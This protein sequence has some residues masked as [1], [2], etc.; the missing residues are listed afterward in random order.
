MDISKNY[1]FYFFLIGFAFFAFFFLIS[2]LG[3]FFLYFIKQRMKKKGN[4]TSL[5]FLEEVFV[6]F[7]IG[8]SVYISFSYLL[9][10][11]SLFN[12]IMAYLLIVI[13]DILFLIYYFFRNKE[14]LNIKDNIKIYFKEFLTKG[15]NKFSLGALAFTLTIIFVIQW[16]IITEATSLNYTDPFKWYSDIF[17]LIDY[18]HINYFHLDYN[19]PSG[20]TFFN[21]GVLLIY[22]DYIFGYYYI[23]MIPLYFISLYVIIALVII[24]KLFKKNYLILLSLLMILCSRY[25][26]SRTL[27]YLSS[28]LASGILIIS[29]II[30]IN[31]YPDYIMGFFIAGL[32]FIH[33]LT[34]F[35]FLVVLSVFYSYKLISKMKNYEIFLKQFYSI[36]LLIL[37]TFILLIPYLVSIYFIYNDTIFDFIGHFFERFEEAD[38]AYLFKDSSIS[39]IGLIRLVFPLDYFTPFIERELLDSFDELFERSIFLFFIFSILGVVKYF[40]SEKNIKNKEILIF[41]KIFIIVILIFFFLPFIFPS[42]NLFIKFRKRILQSFNLP[43]IIMLLYAVEWLVSLAKKLTNYLAFRFKFYRNLLNNKKFYSK[44]FKIDSI[45]I[46]ILMIS[47][48]STFVMHRYPDY[49]YYHEDELVEVVLYLRTHAESGSRVLRKDYD[50]TPIFRMLYDMKVKEWDLNKSSTYEDLLLEIN[51]RNIDYLI[52][53]KDFFHNETID[54]LITREDDFKEKIDNDEYYLFKIKN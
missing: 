43:I 40:K 3:F 1:V 53:P 52:F 37:I 38:Y 18:G 27:L 32:Y 4:L 25:F 7:G 14:N 46:F 35:Y 39:Y 15:N 45:L 20:Y 10:L 34:A 47:T 31:K 5:S 54:D 29:F 11:F 9:D 33:N 48:S 24:K 16:I 13:F 30:I 42:L 41:F 28:S 6:S 44:F 19:Y 26:L 51:E 23:K 12:F 8:V 17:Y 22:P 2:I 50:Q 21:A 36:S 49:Y